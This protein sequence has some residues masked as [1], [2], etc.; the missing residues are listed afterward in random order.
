MDGLSY[1]LKSYILCG[2]SVATAAINVAGTGYT[3]GDVVNIA[4]GSVTATLKLTVVGGIPTAVTIVNAG[5][6]YSAGTN[7]AT[8]Y[9]GSGVNLTVDITIYSGTVA[10]TLSNIVPEADIRGTTRDK[11]RS[12]GY[13]VIKAIVQGLYTNTGMVAIGYAPVASN[14]STYLG[15]ESGIQLAAG[16]TVEIKQVDLSKVKFI[17]ATSGDGI[18]LNVYISQT[19]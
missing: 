1:L 18:I 2:T 15:T 5:K 14:G 11:S 9:G 7:V 3:N 16:Q 8:S 4:G 12:G 13:Q 19:M 10:V 6:G 17:A